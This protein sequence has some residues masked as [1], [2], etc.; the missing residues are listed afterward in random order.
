MISGDEKL[1]HVYLEPRFIDAF[2]SLAALENNNSSYL[3]NVPIV[4]EA[5]REKRENN[6]SL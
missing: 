5:R 4:S 1:F 2:Q 6:L 3:V